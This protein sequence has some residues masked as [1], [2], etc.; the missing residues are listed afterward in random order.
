MCDIEFDIEIV[1]IICVLVYI[2]CYAN[3]CHLWVGDSPVAV[4]SAPL[5]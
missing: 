3:L 2:E 1:C 4:V 5:V